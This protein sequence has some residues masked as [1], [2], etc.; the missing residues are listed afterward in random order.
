MD[1]VICNFP[2]M[3]PWW[4]PSA[5]AI[6][7]GACSYLGLSSRFIDFN[8]N[9][10]NGNN[11]IESWVDEIFSHDPKV[12]ALSIFSYKSRREFI[13]VCE[14][15][16]E[17]DSDVVIACG[18]PGLRDNINTVVQSD[19]QNLIDQTVIDHY[20]LEDGEY[21]FLK[22]LTD[23]FGISTPD[24]FE[25][26][27]V[28]YY[29]DYSDYNF[30]FYDQHRRSDDYPMFVPVTGSKGCVRN[31][32]FCEIPGRWSFAQRDPADIAEEIRRI[33]PLIKG[34]NY[35]IHFTDSLVNGSLPA[36][37]SMLDH[38]LDIKKE[39][40]E[41]NWG[42]Q[43]IIRRA[44]QSGDDYWKRIADSGGRILEIGIETGSDR[45][46]DEMKK[47]F[48]NEDLYH[49]VQMM[50]KY[51]VDCVFLMFTGMPTETEEDFQDTLKLLTDLQQYKDKVIT[52]IE[53]GYLTTIA[54]NTPLYRSG[55]QDPQMIITK[56]PIIW[57]NK[58]NPDLTFRERINRRVRFEEHARQC[59]YT[60]AWDAHLQVEEA[61]Q[62]YQDKIKIINIVERA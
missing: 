27:R 46:R 16:K 58:S 13:K 56:D 49:S 7:K 40:P 57:Y 2:P 22:F 25:T 36:F 11:D 15:I 37:E 9:S 50:D 61:E 6:L 8:I 39:Y 35:H 48:S 17:R 33:L 41:F 1:V 18:G 45:L 19:I 59:G 47:N 38:F 23:I 54:P 51:G 21:P 20:V 14:L 52:E 53:L 4:I 26:V 62:T 42:G 44:N 3:L 10:I 12:V 34:M 29:P 28:P 24:E 32:T 5:P 55:Q 60:V 31:C 30:E 43:F